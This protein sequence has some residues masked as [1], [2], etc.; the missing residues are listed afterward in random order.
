MIK[1]NLVP[2]IDLFG[3]IQHTKLDTQFNMPS[4]RMERIE[5]PETANFKSVFSGLVE[6]LNTEMAQPDALLKDLMMG[7]KNIDIHDV[8]TAM[9]KAEL[10]VSVATQATTKIIQSYEKIMQI[11]V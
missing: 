10:S 4:A 3:K 1:N 2:N 11:Q 5:K 6:H 7:N 8:M 9:S